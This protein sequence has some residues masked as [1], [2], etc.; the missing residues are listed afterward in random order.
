MNSRS[1]FVAAA[2]IALGAGTLPARAADLLST[3][4]LSASLATEAAT[5]AAAA[6]RKLGFSTTVAV[7]DADGV[8]QALVRDD[9]AGIHTVQAAQDKAFTAATYGRPTSE[10]VKRQEARGAFAVI[11]KQPHLLADEGGLPIKVGTELIAAIG[12][13]GSAGKDEDCGSAGID[14]IKN[15]LK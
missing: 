5:G 11:V 3:H 7:T 12:V 6:C 9:G 4:R 8:L 2:L 13:S 10:V 1:F 14:L 15:R